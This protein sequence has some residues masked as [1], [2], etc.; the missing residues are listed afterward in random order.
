MLFTCIWY[1]NIKMSMNRNEYDKNKY[2]W[3]KWIWYFKLWIRQ[4]IP[5]RKKIKKVIS[6][7]LN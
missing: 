6:I 2:E 7:K 4:N 5:E 1:K 3:I